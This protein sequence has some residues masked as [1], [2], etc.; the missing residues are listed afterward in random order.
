MHDQGTVPDFK[1]SPEQK[2]AFVGTPFEKDEEAMKQTIAAKVYSGDPSALATPEQKAWV[3]KQTTPH[4]SLG[5]AFEARR[6]GRLHGLNLGPEQPERP[7]APPLGKP[8]EPGAE[9]EL[10]TLTPQEA[11]K[12]GLKSWLDPSGVE[13]RRA[14][15]PDVMRAKRAQEI[16]D[17]SYE[18]G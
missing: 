8:P 4:Y 6:E 11:D 15:L 9:T 14:T 10:P 7:G 1:I 5:Q 13:V 16:G 18:M 17:T 3:L 12:L 2:K